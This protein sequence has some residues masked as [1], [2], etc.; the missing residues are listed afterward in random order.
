[1]EKSSRQDDL[2]IVCLNSLFVSKREKEEAIFRRVMPREVNEK[3][4]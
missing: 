4:S 2:I 1:M 3:F